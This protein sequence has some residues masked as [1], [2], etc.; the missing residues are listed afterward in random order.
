MATLK[1]KYNKQVTK[2]LVKKFNYENKMEIPK[3]MKVVVNRGV[4]EATIETKSIEASAVELAQI[5]GQLPQRIRAKKSIATFN[6]R[7]GLEIGLKVTLRGDRMYHFM[8]KLI[9]VCLPKIRDFQGV[10][11][12]AFD[13][14]GNYTLGVKE[15]LI[16]P[17][18]DYDSVD[19]VRGMDITIVTSAQTNAEAKELL[20]LLGVP[21][22]KI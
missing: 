7:E 16:F 18:V 22:R 15:Q 20:R 3:I 12:N 9:N 2:E 10:N 4:S 13:G 1:E 21:F 5:T 19:R 6:L 11:P 8:D 14:R 17:E